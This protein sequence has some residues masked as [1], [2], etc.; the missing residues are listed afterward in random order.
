MQAQEPLFSPREAAVQ[1]YLLVVAV[2]RPLFPVGYWE[3]HRETTLLAQC[4]R[5]AEDPVQ[6]LP[7]S[8]KQWGK[9]KCPVP[10]PEGMG[11]KEE[12]HGDI[13]SP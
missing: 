8:Y 12:L 7:T 1:L 6:P 3:F 11:G 9:G 13:P 10:V 2:F 4:R 5:G